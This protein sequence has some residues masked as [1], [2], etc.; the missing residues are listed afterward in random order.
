ML[1]LAL[2]YRWGPSRDKPRWR[3]LTPGSIVAAILWLVISMLFSWYVSNFGSYDAT[4][5][6][7]GAAIGFMTWIWISTIVVLIGAEINAETEHQTAKDTT[8]GA[9]EPI[10][11]RGATVADTVGEAKA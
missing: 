4:Y 11:S 1:G 3:W 6:S 2:I 7:L 10:G 9:R 8:V 5:G